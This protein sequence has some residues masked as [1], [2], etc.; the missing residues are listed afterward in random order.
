METCHSENLFFPRDQT[1]SAV[2]PIAEPLLLKESGGGL[3]FLSSCVVVGGGGGG[4][5]VFGKSTAISLEWSGH[6]FPTKDQLLACHASFTA[7]DASYVTGRAEQL[8][9]AFPH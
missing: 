3:K 2:Q 4:G 1:L 9:R 7:P 8:P 6:C 5:L